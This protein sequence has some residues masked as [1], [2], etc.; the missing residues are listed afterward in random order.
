MRYFVMLTLLPAVALAILGLRATAQP[1]SMVLGTGGVPEPEVEAPAPGT[2]SATAPA[3]A[4]EAAAASLAPVAEGQPL[5]SDDSEL[6]PAAEPAAA[7]AGWIAVGLCQPMPVTPETVRLA[8]D[9][10]LAAQSEPGST[11]PNVQLTATSVRFGDY[12]VVL[13]S[14]TQR[15]TVTGPSG[16]DVLKRDIERCISPMNGTAIAEAGRWRWSGGS[17]RYVDEPLERITLPAGGADGGLQE[18]PK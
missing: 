4:P 5:T 15:V 16:A 2:L 8:F 7:S 9:P 13:N 3:L 1:P 10:R 18:D 6:A 14:T 17:W 11:P 12:E